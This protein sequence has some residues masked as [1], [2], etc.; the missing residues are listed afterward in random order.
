MLPS[1]NIELIKVAFKSLVFVK[2]CLIYGP[3]HN[4]LNCCNTL[5]ILLLPYFHEPKLRF[6]MLNWASIFLGGSELLFIC[7]SQVLN[8]LPL[9]YVFRPFL[10]YSLR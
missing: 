8:F 1:K 6:I 7:H 3:F 9:N 4:I 2:K 5:N 10:R